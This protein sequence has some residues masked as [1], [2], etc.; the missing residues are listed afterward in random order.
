[1]LGECLLY[2][3]T[4]VLVSPGLDRRND[5]A[6]LQWI[7]NDGVKSDGQISAGTVL[8]ESCGGGLGEVGLDKRDDDDVSEGFKPSV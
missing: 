2:F 5:D 6:V 1:M 7:D 4:V 8:V 3:V